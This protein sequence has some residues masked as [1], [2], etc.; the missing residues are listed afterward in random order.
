MHQ[1][2]PRVDG[3]LV[4][5]PVAPGGHGDLGVRRRPEQLTASTR[6]GAG[7]DLDA[8]QAVEESAGPPAG[9]RHRWQADGVHRDGVQQLPP[10]MRQGAGGVEHLQQQRLPGD[11]DEHPG[12]ER[13]RAQVVGRRVF[14][15]PR[16]VEQ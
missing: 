11:A 16:R 13:E 5:H 3:D 1:L 6:I 14:D 2:V 10:G 7:R 12:L 8:A 4:Q 9:R 15:R